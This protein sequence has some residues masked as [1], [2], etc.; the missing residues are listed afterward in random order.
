[1]SFIE[2]NLE[3]ILK[4][5]SKLDRDQKPKWGTMNAQGMVEHL[6]DSIRIATG[7]LDFKLEIPETAIPKMQAFLASEK[8]MPIDFKPPFV[9]EK[10]KLRNEEL[11][12]AV[13]EFTQVWLNYEAYYANSNDAAVSHP[14][15][16]PLNYDQWQ[17]L[18]AK[19]ITHH[20]KQFD[21]LD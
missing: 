18:H 20:L 10:I 7:E 2:P 3:L 21:L 4:Y 12:L 8:P 1:M 5:L 16:G 6:S 9:P 14:Y 19:H 17:R 13:D 11:E 15:Y